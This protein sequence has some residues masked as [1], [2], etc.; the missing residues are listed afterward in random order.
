MA[1]D[2]GNQDL[3]MVQTQKCGAVNGIPMG[4][5]YLTIQS[6]CVCVAG[7]IFCFVKTRNSSESQMIST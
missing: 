3:G 7:Y 6:Y 4:Q 1:Y 5:Y 2:V